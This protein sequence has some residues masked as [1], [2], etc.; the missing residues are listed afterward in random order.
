MISCQSKTETKDR[1][2][3]IEK[4]EKVNTEPKNKSIQK[5]KQITEE[6]TPKNEIVKTEK[7]ELAKLIIDNESQYST[8]FIHKLRAANG[9]KEIE[10]QGGKM[11]L[12]KKDSINFPEIPDLNRRIKFTGRKENLAIALSINRINYTSVEYTIEMVEFGKSSKT[13][14]GIADLG[15]FFFLGS[16]SD[17]DELTGNGYFSTEFSNTKDSCYTNIR[18]GNLDESN[19][20]PLLAKIIKNCNGEIMDINLDNFPTLREK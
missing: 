11:I 4:T 6:D 3:K 17:T 8:N 19:N 10:F 1:I 16:E 14:N 18:I 9:M 15:G 20:K 12:N 5:E 2:P 7:K 13:D